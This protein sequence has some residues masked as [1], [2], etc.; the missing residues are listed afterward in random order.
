MDLII[1]TRE[2]ITAE[3]SK[4]LTPKERLQNTKQLIAQSQSANTL[5]GLLDTLSKTMSFIEAF[6]FTGMNQVLNQ[7]IPESSK[8]LQVILEMLAD[9]QLHLKQNMQLKDDSG[10][11]DAFLKFLETHNIKLVG[12]RKHC[13]IL[14]KQ[15]DALTKRQ[16]L[17]SE[18]L[19]SFIINTKG[20]KSDAELLSMANRGAKLMASTEDHNIEITNHGTSKPAN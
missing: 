3:P 20:E 6:P 4:E 14:I 17:R 1:S 9:I 13:D 19:M 2:L 7:A 8:E 5:T 16:E 12:T 18:L 10:E 15:R 11:T